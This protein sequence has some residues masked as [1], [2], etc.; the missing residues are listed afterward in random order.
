M[1]APRAY[2]ADAVVLKHLRIGETDRILTLLSP[3]LGKFRAVA[4]GVSKPGSRMAG[5]LEPLTHSALLVA[6]GRNLDIVTQAQTVEGFRTVREDLPLASA[7]IYAAEL[8]ERFTEEQSGSPEVFHL[9]LTLL[10]WLD[11]APAAELPLRWFEAQ[12][13]EVTGFRPEL[14]RC[15]ECQ[16]E[17]E[18]RS[19]YFSPHA[20]GMLCSRCAGD[21]VRVL[22]L[23]AQKVL[24]LL[25]RDDMEP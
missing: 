5:H 16:E 25:Q 20:G 13:L 24:R 14:M 15:I 2:R 23:N 1:P 18:P 9:L 6:R 4:K 7:A 10:R 19:H 17:L 22:S 21:G 3:D 12:L 11:Q 8:A